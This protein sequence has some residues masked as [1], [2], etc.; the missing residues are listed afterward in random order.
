MSLPTGMSAHLW[1]CAPYQK[2][3][4]LIL[5]DFFGLSEVFVVKIQ[6]L[7]N[8]AKNFC[9]PIFQERRETPVVEHFTINHCTL[10]FLEDQSMSPTRAQCRLDIPA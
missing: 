6:P 10:H 9:A 7:P 5:L 1:M 4:I 3:V 2:R 8:R